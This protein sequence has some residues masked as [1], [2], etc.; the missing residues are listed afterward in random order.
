V[1]RPLNWRTV[2]AWA[3][4][5]WANSAFALT[6]MA[7][8]FPV[9]FGKYWSH[10]VD[11][12]LTTMR[13]GLAN[14]GAGLAIAVLSPVLG[15]L[16]DAGRSRKRFLAFFMML[17]VVATGLLYAVPQ[18]AWMAAIVVFVIA[19]MG[20]SSSCMFYDSLLPEVAPPEMYD[21]VSS[22]GYSIGYIGCALLFIV[23]MVM[24]SKPGLF[25]L[26]GEAHAV[27]ASFLSAAVW[28]FVF[29]IPLLLFV[30]ESRG[31]SE[32]RRSWR[33]VIADGLRQ[34]R[35]T[36]GEV[37]TKRSILLFLLAYWLYIDGVGTFI[38]MAGDFGIKMGLT[39]AQ[40][41]TALLLVQ[42]VAF[43]SVFL[44]GLLAQRWNAFSVILIG[45]AVY[46]VVTVLGSFT[47]STARQF[48]IF[49]A[50]SGV[51]LGALQALSRSYFAKLIPADRSA[52]YFG[53]Y[54]LL[55]KFAVV[56]GPV[57]IG[58]VGY[59]ARA[60]GASTGLAGRYG[61]GSLA[62]LFVAGGILL[63]A[64]NSARVKESA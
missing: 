14:S 4:Y 41:M 19:N 32:E 1:T 9:F 58:G 31:S 22:L 63:V 3:F 48:T 60:C 5:D 46:V 18:G 64:A 55:G 21:T 13:L 28:W 24:V 25:G 36:I 20:F 23:N 2:F 34:L 15:A 29:S 47:L 56:F 30:R 62:L 59:F 54:D 40:L 16:A 45:I 61:F 39:T 35:L 37:V 53:F 17:G 33:R 8:F 42:L 27:R 26:H 49:A 52:E 11:P 12:T 51:P 10:G 7:A 50:I 44:F 6:V 57:M 43:P 38:R